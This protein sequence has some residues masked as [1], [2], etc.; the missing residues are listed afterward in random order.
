MRNMTSSYQCMLQ[1]VFGVLLHEA[2][3]L[4]IAASATSMNQTRVH[5]AISFANH[6][7]LH[8]ILADHLSTISHSALKQSDQESPHVLC[9]FKCR[10]RTH[11]GHDGWRYHEGVHANS[12]YDTSDVSTLAPAATSITAQSGCFSSIASPRAVGPSY[13]R[14]F[15]IIHHKCTPY[16]TPSVMLGISVTVTTPAGMVNPMTLIGA[17]SRGLGP[18]GQ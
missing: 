7:V 5:D 15:T 13:S 3:I 12:E 4:S 14:S 8:A 11:Y 18:S 6:S 10:Y 17:S 1:S 9:F 2:D 16:T